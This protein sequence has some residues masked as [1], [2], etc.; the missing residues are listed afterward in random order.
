MVKC[1][2]QKSVDRI[3]SC[4]TEQR[5]RLSILDRKVLEKKRSHDRAAAQFRRA[6]EVMNASK[7]DVVDPISKG[8]GSGQRGGVKMCEQLV[9]SMMD[10]VREASTELES[11]ES[12]LERQKERVANTTGELAAAEE[13]MREKLE[14][15]DTSLAELQA[16]RGFLAS[17]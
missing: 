13:M 8:G 3:R 14:V 9:N 4:L 10:T 7:V 6:R 11:W 15:V 5:Q 12:K 1:D 16:L 17:L 2:L